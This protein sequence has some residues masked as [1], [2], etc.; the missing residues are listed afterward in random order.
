M[1]KV[2]LIGRTNV[3][4]STLFNRLTRSRDAIVADDAGL[5]RDR[6]YG[7]VESAGRRW[8]LIDTGG[9][10]D[11]AHGMDA[12]V[13]EQVAAQSE[14]AVAE[15]D[16]VCFV[17]DA[18]EGLTG[19]DETVV[20]RLRRAGKPTWLVVNKTDGCDE[21]VVTAEFASLALAPA[22]QTAAVQGHGVGALR[23]A[24]AQQAEHR[25]DDLETTGGVRVTFL[26]RPNV[27]KS[28]LL[29]RLLGEE[30]TL[31]GA[32]P[33]TTRDSIAAPFTFNGRDFV[34]VDTAGV[35]RRS[36][37]DARVEKFS[38]L[39]TLESVMLADVVVLV[40]DAADG[41]TSQDAALAGRAVAAGRALVV[42]VNKND[43]L[44]DDQSRRK[45][46][47]SRDLGLHFL[48]WAEVVTLSA[49]LNRGMKRLMNA[50]C[51]A[52]ESARARVPTPRCTRLLLSAVE[53]NQP[54]MVPGGRVKLRYA[55]QGGTRPPRFIVYGARVN[56]LPA[57]Y[58][59]YLENFFREQ[60]KLV[61]TPVVFEFRRTPNR[62]VD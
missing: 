53:R 10:T 57:S 52:C 7:C 42:A 26:G 48:R 12:A 59:R 5:T 46:E 2:A 41:V 30:R 13:T 25:P 56:G 62:F 51:N 32:A 61:G 54:P 18:R 28:T 36:K 14:W 38:V 33:G 11:D 3:G 60:L 22:F 16:L 50:V 39:K 17:A 27:G 19:A 21:H 4:K 40:C 43:L 1:L 47:R 8:L 23:S 34:L 6:H 55:H 58:R 35:R 29:N 20:Q 49:L 9:L 45:L 15:A 44:G 37:V 24:L 31:T